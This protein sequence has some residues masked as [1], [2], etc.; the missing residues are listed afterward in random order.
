MCKGVNFEVYFLPMTGEQIIIIKKSWRI[1]RS[2]NPKT[3]GDAFYTKLFADTPA[4]RKM[5][6][7][8]MN[9]QYQ[10]LMDMLNAIVGR[11]DR[12]D[13]L[14]EEIVAMAQRHIDYGVIPAHYKLVGDAL[15]WTLEKGLGS[16][17]NE[18]VKIAWISCYSLLSDTMIRSAYHGE[19]YP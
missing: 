19:K 13:Q 1:F 15:L 17:W 5:F 2:M 7:Q 8:G 9:E 18:E 14:S 6:P 12:F 16:D 4:L 11:L 10:K 3:V